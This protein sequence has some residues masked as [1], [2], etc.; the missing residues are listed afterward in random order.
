MLFT[1]RQ[2]SL[3]ALAG[4]AAV[5]LSACQ[6]APVAPVSGPSTLLAGPQV[7]D[8]G[9]QTI[10]LPSNGGTVV[11]GNNDYKLKLPANAVCDPS[12]SSYGP[13]EWDSPCTPL[14]RDFQVTATYRKVDGHPQVT[15]S[16]DIRF[17]P[18]SSTNESDWVMLYMKD[19][20]AADAQ[21]GAELKIYWVPTS[22]DVAVDE[23]VIDPSVATHLQ[24]S[25]WSIYRRLK[26]FSGYQVGSGLLRL[27]IGM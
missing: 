23:S 20:D 17:Q 11:F 13:T 5:A 18:T 24:P 8:E 3:A 26:H 6:D 4:V 21:L 25:S 12:V 10:T 16:P 7:T 1:S 2:R 19:K 27:S 22:G 14:G 9:T 15:F